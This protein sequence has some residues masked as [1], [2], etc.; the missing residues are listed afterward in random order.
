MYLHRKV[1][2]QNMVQSI[3]NQYNN[4]VIWFSNRTK[5]LSAIFAWI[6]EH[7]LF[8]MVYCLPYA[9]VNTYS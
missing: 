3:A 4:W 7:K 2:A 8:T 5:A 9:S 1:H 6:D